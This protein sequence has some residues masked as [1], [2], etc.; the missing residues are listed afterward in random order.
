APRKAVRIVISKT[1]GQKAMQK[2]WLAR[3]RKLQ[4]SFCAAAVADWQS[5]RA[6]CGLLAV[7]RCS[8]VK[9]VEKCHGKWLQAELP[10][11]QF[12]IDRPGGALGCNRARGP[13]LAASLAP[14]S[15]SSG[16]VCCTFGVR[17]HRQSHGGAC[18]AEEFYAEKWRCAVIDALGN[19]RQLVGPAP[20]MGLRDAAAPPDGLLKP[21]AAADRFLNFSVAA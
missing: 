2:L 6:R 13:T 18:A 10:C 19:R 12:S 9:R 1:R 3:A 20:P 8:A 5:Q 16:G 7:G 17:L 4:C 14:Q 21:A 11:D 15:G